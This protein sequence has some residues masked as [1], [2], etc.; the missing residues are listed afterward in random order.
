MKN[1]RY[2]NILNIDDIFTSP[3]CTI[4]TLDIN[5]D[6]RYLLTRKSFKLVESAVLETNEDWAVS[7]VSN[8]RIIFQRNDGSGQDLCLNQSKGREHPEMPQELRDRLIEIYEPWNE[9]FF[10]MIGREMDWGR[11][12]DNILA[13]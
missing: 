8:S 7:Q 5:L 9:K 10:S 4:R 3:Y 6:Y 11:K 13:L 12:E 1:H 2:C